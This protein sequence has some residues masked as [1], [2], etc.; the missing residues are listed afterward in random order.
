MRNAGEIFREHPIQ[1]IAIAP[2]GCAMR[3]Q[4]AERLPQHAR[5]FRALLVDA[6]FP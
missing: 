5:Q 2:Y 6:V 4:L 1:R 3:G